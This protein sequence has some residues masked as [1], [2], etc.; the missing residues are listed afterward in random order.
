MHG[1]QNDKYT[2]MHGQQNVKKR[3]KRKRNHMSYN[4]QL[5][6]WK[7]GRC[8]AESAR[9]SRVQ[10]PRSNDDLQK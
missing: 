6:D 5:Q 3:K 10:Q 4:R 9:Y 7:K 2:E 8:E 1:Q